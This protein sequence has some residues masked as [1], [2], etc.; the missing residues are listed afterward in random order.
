M[1]ILGKKETRKGFDERLKGFNIA[2]GSDATTEL[3][4]KADYFWG[5][6]AKANVKQG[7][8]ARQIDDLGLT[9]VVPIS[10]A[11]STSDMA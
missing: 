3:H 10:S 11:L 4:L 2:F 9:N 7:E 8:L 5:G 1:L 6:Q